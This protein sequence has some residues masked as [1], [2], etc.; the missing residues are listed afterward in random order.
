MVIKNYKLK[1]IILGNN[2]ELK[3]RLFRT[4][5]QSYFERIYK[6]IVGV[7]IGV[8][9]IAVNDMIISLCLW[10]CLCQN[11]TDFLRIGFYKGSDGAIFCYD[12]NFIENI[13]IHINEFQ[14]FNK[15]SL[16]ILFVYMKQNEKDPCFLPINEKNI[17]KFQGLDE[18]LNWFIKVMLNGSKG[19]KIGYLG[20]LRDSLPEVTILPEISSQV[21]HPEILSPVLENM[22][23]K[24]LN[25]E[26]VNILK[27]NAL[28]S[29]NLVNANV[30]IYPLICDECKRDCKKERD[31]CIVLST[32]GW[33]TF[34]SLN[35]KDLLILSKIYAL[36]NLQYE[37]LPKG[38]KNQIKNILFCPK[39]SK[40]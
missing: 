21:S 3:T 12:S 40:K 34:P 11:R 7:D 9:E 26:N 35:Q 17:L 24:V 36:A 1:S 15:K 28:F 18:A 19:Y 22:G 33:S 39:F 16:P 29:V 5:S 10:D 13:T 37:E 25:K 14:K 20:L 2:E 38:I 23:F 4:I 31:I 30:K 32:K 27:E 6:N 8:A